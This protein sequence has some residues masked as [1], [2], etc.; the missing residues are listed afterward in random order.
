VFRPVVVQYSDAYSDKNYSLNHSLVDLCEMPDS[1]MYR[2]VNVDKQDDG[3]A[4]RFYHL[5][6]L[7]AC[8]EVLVLVDGVCR[9]KDNF[10]GISVYQFILGKPT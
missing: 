7:R 9:V 2:V 10:K 1:G 5:K 8:T 3:A 6:A 4:R